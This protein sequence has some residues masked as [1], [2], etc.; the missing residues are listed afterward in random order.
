MISHAIRPTHVMK[1]SQTTESSETQCKTCPPSANS[2]DTGGLCSKGLCPGTILL[3]VFGI[4][5]GIV[6][7][8]GWIRG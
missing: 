5:Y 6:S 7:L 8:V 4:I 2:C 1:T 3:I